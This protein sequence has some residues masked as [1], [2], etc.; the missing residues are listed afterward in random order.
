MNIS[1]TKTER[2]AR[3]AEQRVNNAL[4]KIRLIGNL[5]SPQYEFTAEQVEKIMVALQAA[6]AEMEEKFQ[7]PL[8]RKFKKFQF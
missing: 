3:L 4:D 6:I 2:F 5:A 7:K 1:E 8:D